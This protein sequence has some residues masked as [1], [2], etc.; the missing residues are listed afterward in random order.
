MN[1]I[2]S[3]YC[4]NTSFSILGTLE[5]L[6]GAGCAGIEQTVE[7]A[8]A[9]EAKLAELKR[10]N[11]ELGETK[12]KYFK[13]SPCNKESDIKRLMKCLVYIWMHVY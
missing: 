4:N 1:D 3:N 8:N 7:N 12:R 11:L 10:H 5:A 13:L 6:G 2:N 9:N